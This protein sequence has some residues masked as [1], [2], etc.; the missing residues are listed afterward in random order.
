MTSWLIDMKDRVLMEYNALAGFGVFG[1]ING[2]DDG[3]HASDY[4][5]SN[6]QGK[7]TFRPEWALAYCARDPNLLASLIASAC[8]NLDKGL[9][10][11][12]L[13][14]TR[15][16][17]TKAIIALVCDRHLIV[18]K[19]GESRC[20]LVRKKEERSGG[21]MPPVRRRRGL[22]T[23]AA[24]AGGDHRAH[25]LTCWLSKSFPCWRT[26]SSISR[27]SASALNPLASRCRPTSCGCCQTAEIQGGTPEEDLPRMR[28]LS[29]IASG[30]WTATSWVYPAPLA[31]LTKS[32]MPDC[33]CPSRRWC[34][35]PTLPSR[36]A[37]TMR[38]CT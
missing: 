27:V 28:W 18:A 23:G 7:L 8:H 13:R 5:A 38:T 9:R 19:V 12:A 32:R 36:N 25:G 21:G 4:V 16:G 11:D 26:T 14:L 29:S 17:R 33:R 6:L 37:P 30:I 24:E 20:I 2:H 35:H 31:I 1:V 10:G 15:D 34:A 22:L 3:G